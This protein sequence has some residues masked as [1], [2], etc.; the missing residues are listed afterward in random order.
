VSPTLAGL[1]IVYALDLTRFLKHGTAMASKTESD[2]NSAERIVQY[3]KPEPEAAFETDPEVAKTM[4]ADWPSAGAITV[5]KLTLRYRPGMPLVLKGVSFSIGAG[6]KVG[7]VGRTGSGKSSL[8]L[9]LFR[10]VE[11]ESGSVFIDGVD[12]STLGL[13]TLRSGMSIIPQEP[14]MFRRAR[15]TRRSLARCA[16]CARAAAAARCARWS[17]GRLRC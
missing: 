15:A 10:M 3:L 11:P 2:F 13:A 12:T 1:T 5:S 16:A 14:F 7:I 6:E 17:T 8:L 4:P 9:A